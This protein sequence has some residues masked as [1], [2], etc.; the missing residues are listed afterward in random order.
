MNDND[1]LIKMV[2]EDA[3]AYMEQNKEDYDKQLQSFI[4]TN[5]CIYGFDLARGKLYTLPPVLTS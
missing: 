3:V 4:E 1:L 2:S 5:K